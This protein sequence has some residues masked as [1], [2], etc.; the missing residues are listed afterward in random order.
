ME[1]PWTTVAGLWTEQF[2][3]C[4][5]PNNNQRTLFNRHRRIPD[6]KFQSVVAP[7]GLT[8]SLYGPFQGKKHDSAGI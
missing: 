2:N 5:R 1:Q 8:A 7:K 4:A 6:I 3:K